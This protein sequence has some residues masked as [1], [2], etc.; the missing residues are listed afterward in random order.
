MPHVKPTLQLTSLN[1]M[2]WDALLLLLAAFLVAR[3]A[4]SLTLMMERA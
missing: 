3:W 2:S 1:L 4:H